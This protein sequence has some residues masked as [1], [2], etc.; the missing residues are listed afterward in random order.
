MTV[1]PVQPRILTRLV[2]IV[3][4]SQRTLKLR[5]P[6]VTL[7]RLAEALPMPTSQAMQLLEPVVSVANLMILNV[8]RTVQR[9]M[10][11]V[12]AQ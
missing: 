8:R 6:L 2:V 3:K 11:A 5:Y 12:E 4:M 1:Y 7:L 9:I 10:R